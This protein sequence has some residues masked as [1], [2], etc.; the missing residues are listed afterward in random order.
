MFEIIHRSADLLVID[1]PSGAALFA[2][3]TG[4]PCLWDDIKSHLGATAPL[5]V[6][7]LDKG[8][9][10]VLLIAL[11]KA[12]QAMLNRAFNDRSIGKF[13]AARV[14][15]DLRLSGTGVIELPLRKGRKSRYRVAGQRAAIE[16]V[17][18]RFTLAA[19]ADDGLECETRVRVVRHGEG[20]TLLSLQPVTGRTHQ[21][22]VHLAWIG[23][24]IVGD[25]L[26]GDPSADAQRWP[27]LA[28]HCHRIRLPDGTTFHA[29]LPP[30]VIGESPRPDSAPRKPAGHGGE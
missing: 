10:G 29:P 22:R 2:D 17:G 23:H 7:R 26:Y 11:T 12:R 4:A 25:H 30:A 8:T 19:R 24:P 3:R 6:H 14:V 18:D 9:S 13:Y 28:L 1:K 21:L 20:F 27:R 15:G 16:R 5:P